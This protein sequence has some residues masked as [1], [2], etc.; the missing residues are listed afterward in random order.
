MLPSLIANS[1][2]ETNIDSHSMKSQ[3]ISGWSSFCTLLVNS[4][5]HIKL[6]VVTQSGISLCLIHASSKKKNQMDE[7]VISVSA[8]NHPKNKDLFTSKEKDL[9]VGKGG[10]FS[11]NEQSNHYDVDFL[12]DEME[13][14]TAIF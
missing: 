12:D 3:C 9:V 4:R 10:E 2:V 13:N 14:N 5:K 8:S 7:E 11:T 1:S 6:S